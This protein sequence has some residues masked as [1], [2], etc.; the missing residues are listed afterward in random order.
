MKHGKG[1]EL[2]TMSGY[3]L[4]GNFDSGRKNGEF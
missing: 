1:R 3:Y 4:E 2:Q